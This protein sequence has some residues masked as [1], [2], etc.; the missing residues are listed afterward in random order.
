MVDVTFS[1]VRARL[2][3]EKKRGKYATTGKK[4]YLFKIAVSA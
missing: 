2:L 4:V 3:L 1:G